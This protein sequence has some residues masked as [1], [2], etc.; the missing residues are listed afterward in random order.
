M[1]L[2]TLLVIGIAIVAV[3]ANAASSFPCRFNWALDYGHRPGFVTAGASAD[4]GGRAGSLTLGVRL[5]RRDEATH[6]WNTVKRRTRTFHHLNGNRFVEVATPCAGA[7]FKAVM[8]WT[9]RASGG[10]V[11]ARHVV[12]TAVLAVPSPHCSFTIS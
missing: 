12:R 6:A 11:V 8:R 4:C 7:R 10:A 5:L 1:K 9:L 2:A 3:H